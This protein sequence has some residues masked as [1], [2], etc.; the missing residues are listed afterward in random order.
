[1]ILFVHRMM[2]S[3]W[4]FWNLARQGITRLPSKRL[5]TGWDGNENYA[6]F[7][8]KMRVSGSGV[9]TQMGGILEWLDS[10]VKA[11]YSIFTFSMEEFIHGRL[12]MLPAPMHDAWRAVLSSYIFSKRHALLTPENEDIIVKVN[13]LIL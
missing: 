8:D 7:N 10:V 11:S 2:L 4:P 12:Q 9:S 6:L 5:A 3:C 1:M 13:V